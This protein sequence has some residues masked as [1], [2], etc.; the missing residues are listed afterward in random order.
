[1]KEG[2]TFHKEPVLHK[3]QGN[4]DEVRKEEKKKEASETRERLQT[5]LLAGL[6]QLVTGN[7]RPVQSSAPPARPIGRSISEPVIK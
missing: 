5:H 6:D 2:K 3:E 4:K 1:M 7:S